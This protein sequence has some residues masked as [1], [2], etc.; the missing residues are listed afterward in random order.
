MI[1][2]VVYFEQS[3]KNF[4]IRC[5]GQW[6]KFYLQSHGCKVGKGLKCIQFPNFR[7]PP[8]QNIF[9]GDNVTVGEN[10]TLEVVKGATLKIKNNVNLTRNITLAIQI[11]VEIGN[12]CL[13]GENVSIRDANHQTK[14]AK[15]IMTQ[16]SDTDEISIGEDV[17]IGANS[18]VL[19]GAKI[20]NGVVI[21]ANSLVLKK[22][23]LEPYEIYGGTPLKLL[24]KRI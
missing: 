14:K 6:L 23:V 22:L 20:P 16:P 24:K 10:I 2:F 5:K 3:C 4:K 13:I 19:K 15:I 21:G 1:D 9:L 18:V 17:W 8:N 11:G 12:N 7:L